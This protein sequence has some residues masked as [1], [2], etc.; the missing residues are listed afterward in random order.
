MKNVLFITYYFPPSGG[1][2][3]QRGLKFSKYL[4]EFGWNPIIL[5]ADS[6]FLKQPK[7]FSL[8]QEV[9][10]SLSVYRSFTFDVNWLFKI[11]WGL[12]LSG[13]VQYLQHHLFV[14]D[15]EI[16]WLPFARRKIREILKIHR[17]DLVF[18]SGPPFSP[19]ILGKWIKDRY[20]IPYILDYRDDWSLGQS[21]LDNPPPYKFQRKD[22]HL[23]SLALENAEHVTVVIKT[24]IE[25]FVKNYSFMNNEKLT[26]IPNGYDEADFYQIVTPPYIQTN[27]MRIVFPGAL[28]DRRHPA[29]IWKALLSLVNEKRVNPNSI[30]IDRK[31][32]V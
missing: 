20:N 8:L 14:P 4:S 23:E 10:K 3:V 13:I 15:I 29:P 18:I 12:R 7:D 9:S 25:D 11:F 24:Y 22:K 2:G 5:C 16:I 28:Y 17:I 19:M 21:R 30:S 32:V 6:R 27:K 26:A 1:S 31:S